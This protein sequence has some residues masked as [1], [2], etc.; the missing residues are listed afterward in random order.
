MNRI[1]LNFR[2][3]IITL[4]LTGL[5]YVVLADN[6]TPVGSSHITAVPLLATLEIG[7]PLE[8]EGYIDNTI[9]GPYPGTL[10]MIIKAPMASRI[11]S[12]TSLTPNSD[13]TFSYS[14]ITDITGTWAVSARYGGETSAVSEVKVTP[15]ETV[16]S[17]KNILNSFGGLVTSRDEVVMTG[18]LRDNLGIGIANKPIQCMV[19]LPPY[20]CSI[21]DFEDL[22]IW[23][24]HGTVTTDSSGRYAFKFVPNERGQFRARTYFSG[25]EIYRGAV[26]ETRSIRVT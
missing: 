3:I 11:D 7:E 4:I 1:I 25:D 15:R 8:I 12:F 18:Y 2:L 9:F 6:T 16:K 20:G 23:Q 24:D 17:V 22:L 13:G 26:S 19:A 21:C 14:V 5:C 10:I